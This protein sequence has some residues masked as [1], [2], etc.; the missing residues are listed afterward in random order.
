MKILT[1]IVLSV[2]CM[3]APAFAFEANAVFNESDSFV[4]AKSVKLGY[5]DGSRQAS[6]MT[7]AQKGVCSSN[8][9]C[10]PSQMCKD[11]KCV[12]ACTSSTCTDST[13]PKCVVKDHAAVCTCTDSSCGSGKVCKDGKCEVCKEGDS[14]NCP[15]AQVSDG[16]GGC[17]CAGAKS[18]SAGQYYKENGCS[19]L[20]CNKD[21]KCDCAGDSVSDGFGSCYCKETESCSDGQKSNPLTCK[22][23]PCAAG[24]NNDCEKPCPSGQVPDGKGGCSAV[25]CFGDSDCGAGMQCKN[26]GLTDAECVACAKDTQC[27]CPEGQLADGKGGC[28]EIKCSSTVPCAAGNTCENAGT[29]DST[30]RPCEKGEPCNCTEGQIADGNG[31][32]VTPACSKDSDCPAGKLCENAGTVDAG[33]VSCKEN[34]PCPT[35]PT[36]YVSDG[37]GGCKPGCTFTNK[38]TCVSGTANCAACSSVGGCF[39]CTA[40]KTGYTLSGSTCVA[41][42]TVNPNCE[43][44]SSE[45]SCVKCEDGYKVV[46]GKCVKKTCEELGLSTSCSAGYTPTATK[47]DGCVSCSPIDGYCANNSACASDEKCENNTCVPVTCGECQKVENHACTKVKG[48]CTSNA[49]CDFD[50]ACTNG[51]CQTLTCGECRLPT[52]HKCVEISDCCTKDSDC[53]TGE[54]CDSNNEC[55]PKACP[56]GY[57]TSV[58]TCDKGYKLEKNGQ[59]G[60]LPCGKCVKASC[61]EQGLL[62]S[63]YSCGQG[64]WGSNIE[65]CWKCMQCQPNHTNGAGSDQC[66]TKT[67]KQINSSYF[68]PTDLNGNFIYTGDV[69]TDGKCAKLCTGS[70]SNY[71]ID[72]KWCLSCPSSEGCEHS[73][74]ST[75]HKCCTSCFPGYTLMGSN[76]ACI[77]NSSTSASRPQVCR[78]HDECPEGHECT[79]G[80]YSCR[81]CAIGSNLGQNHVGSCNCPVNTWSDGHGHCSSNCPSGYKKK[82]DY[83]Y[84]QYYC[85]NY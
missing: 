8:S 32:C 84:K 55:K 63:K 49:D 56:S 69:G 58:T 31:G 38:A 51:Q 74:V 48:C 72:H 9:N 26:P 19:C 66:T 47:Y 21:E 81:K 79:E 82:Y 76:S 16:S 33:C 57:S 2:C 1:S 54:Q 4:I 53:G 13:L 70:G 44:C 12:S 22:C 83:Y 34:E 42:K 20:P 68:V 15:G 37:K 35:C 11:G 73:N 25:A 14:C 45:T 24:N 80:G 75:T 28:A 85:S 40:C 18:C 71:Q 10:L 41:C 52:N 61:E 5:G 3:T 17:Y 36:G 64:S 43:Q 59:S 30:C 67:C 77:K 78:W 46:A 23:E 7:S 50:A 39:E 60:A 62:S 6:P 29:S 27:T 65:G